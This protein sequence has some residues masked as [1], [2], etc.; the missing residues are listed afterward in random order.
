MAVALLAVG[1]TAAAAQT[2]IPGG[3]DPVPPSLR[4]S[5][6]PA[7]APTPA[8]TPAPAPDPAPSPSPNAAPQPAQ[9]SGPSPAEL[10]RREE[11]RRAAAARAEAR[12]R[13]AERR[14]EARRRAA[15]RAEARRVAAARREKLLAAQRAEDA[16]ILAAAQA[17]RET[18][19]PAAASPGGGE[20]GDAPLFEVLL[21]AGLGLVAAGVGYTVVRRGR[22]E[23]LRPV[24]AIVSVIA[25][26]RTELLVGVVAL[27]SGV[28]LLYLLVGG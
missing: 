28:G 13:A 9:P 12:R 10:R 11:A 25:G 15:A 19:S 5:P 23:D 27:A 20:R 7:P 14:A 21:A 24:D 26:R 3:P 2:G 6:P 8:P 22:E 17:A 18:P 16:R 1:A 4:P